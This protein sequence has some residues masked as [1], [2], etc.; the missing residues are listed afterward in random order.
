MIFWEYK[1]GLDNEKNIVLTLVRIMNSPQ[2]ILNKNEICTEHNI[3]NMIKGSTYSIASWELYKG[4]YHV[5]QL[6]RKKRLYS[7]RQRQI[8]YKE[9]NCCVRGVICYLIRHLMG[10]STKYIY[11]ETPRMILLECYKIWFHWFT[12]QN[13][14]PSRI[15]NFI[16]IV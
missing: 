7:S 8:N 1:W 15:L 9:T 4:N 14:R 3:I 11:C 13:Y 5:F 2:D 10:L 12:S 16:L 6:K